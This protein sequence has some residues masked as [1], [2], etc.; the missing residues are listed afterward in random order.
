MAFYQSKTVTYSLAGQMAVAYGTFAFR[1]GAPFFPSVLRLSQAANFNPPPGS[2]I[3]DLAADEANFTGY[4]EA[5]F[6]NGTVT[7]VNLSPAVVG[8]AAVGTFVGTDSG[9]FEPNVVSGYWVDN[10]T[11]PLAWEAFPPPGIPIAGPGDF[12][13]LLAG[14]PF[15]LTQSCQ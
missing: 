3:A 15:R 13:V 12:L 14:M 6:S 9:T 8:V 1:R 5:Q 2:S 11:I 4:S 10:G 7:A